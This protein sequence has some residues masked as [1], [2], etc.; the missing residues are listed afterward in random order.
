M[1]TIEKAVPSDGDSRSRVSLPHGGAVE[2]WALLVAWTP[3]CSALVL[4]GQALPRPRWL[5]SGLPAHWVLKTALAPVPLN[6]WAH[7]G[8]LAT[9]FPCSI[10]VEGSHLPWLPPHRLQGFAPMSSA[11][12]QLGD[13][14]WVTGVHYTCPMSLPSKYL[15]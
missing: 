6:V 10:C 15:S 13:L 9:R 12:G 4:P 1:P 11:G 2:A 8:S 14:F 7:V 3:A 5:G